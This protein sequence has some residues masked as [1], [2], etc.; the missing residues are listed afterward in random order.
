MYQ[1]QE[2]RGVE[3][4]NTRKKEGVVERKEILKITRKTTTRTV[5][6]ARTPGCYRQ[7][8]DSWS[9]KMTGADQ[10]PIP[11]F[12]LVT[13]LS[14]VIFHDNPCS[15]D[16]FGILQNPIVLKEEAADAKVSTN[17]DRKFL[18]GFEIIVLL[19]FGELVL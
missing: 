6:S 18:K 14:L 3:E 7:M 19:S 11:Q 17:F 15:F 10:G 13:I 9:S 2:K 5:L 16:F 1:F 8:N 4:K 12:S